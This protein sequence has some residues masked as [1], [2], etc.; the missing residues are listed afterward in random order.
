MNQKELIE[1]NTGEPVDH[2]LILTKIEERKTK[3][4]N[5][6]LNLELRDKSTVIAAKVW[7]NFS[8]FI[9]EAEAG[10]VVKIKGLMEEFNNSPQI[11]VSSIRLANEKDKVNPSD[12][13]PKSSRSIEEMTSELE[14]RIDAIKNEHLKLLIKKILSGEK[15]AKYKHVPAGKAWHHAYVH[16]LIEHTL[17][18]IRICD[19]ICD[20][21]FELNRDLI[22]TGA[23]LHDFGKT[24]EL[25]YEINFDYTDKGKLL[26][27]IV[28][29]AL[30]IE[31][32]AKSIKNF[33]NDLKDQVIHLV[34]SHQG[35]LE[36]ASPVVPKTLEAI[37]LY[38]ADEL[39]AKV[40]AYKYAI[41]LDEK[42]ESNWTRFQ[43]LAGTAIFIPEKDNP[44]IEP[45]TLFDN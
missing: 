20:I 18:I 35:K 13:L 28:I 11:K 39:S 2:F 12:F 9:K 34:L 16:G 29:A 42:S 19:L 25:N 38:H 31:N 1:I 43:Q 7:D 15:Y 32:A 45:E 24:E 3:T 36:Q 21:H 5:P 23:I 44:D 10:K 30:E 41:K 26:G 6:F 33:P 14:K 27:H 8:D 37:A 4:G 22:I 17:E 40:N